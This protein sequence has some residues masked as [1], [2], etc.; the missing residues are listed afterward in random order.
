MCFFSSFV[1]IRVTLFISRDLST[2]SSVFPAGGQ[3]CISI[4]KTVLG[5]KREEKDSGFYTRRGIC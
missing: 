4:K 3:C 1:E 5:R 2:P